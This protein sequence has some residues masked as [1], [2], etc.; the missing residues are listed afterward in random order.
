MIN[1]RNFGAGVLAG[2]TS[3]LGG[4]TTTT[5]WQ[6]PNT[7]PNNYTLLDC[8]FVEETERAWID[9]KY[10]G[11]K[12]GKVDFELYLEENG[13]FI[14]QSISHTQ[15]VSN[16]MNTRI[17]VD[18]WQQFE[19]FVFNPEEGSIG[20]IIANPTQENADVGSIPV[21]GE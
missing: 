10:T 11:N 13:S 20:L 19:D 6:M 17:S 2:A 4:C 15:S 3:F 1:R 5:V 14:T 16:G 9:V 8:G 12:S 21:S 18:S 7:D